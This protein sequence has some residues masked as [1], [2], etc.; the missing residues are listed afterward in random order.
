MEWASEVVKNNYSCHSKKNGG[1][2]GKSHKDLQGLKTDLKRAL[3]ARQVLSF[4]FWVLL[5]CLTS[6]CQRGTSN[7]EVASF[8]PRLLF[9][10]STGLLLVESPLKGDFLEGN[11]SPRG[12][13]PSEEA[14]KCNDEAAVTKTLV[15]F[16]PGCRQ[17]AGRRIGL[18]WPWPW[19]LLARLPYHTGVKT[20]RNTRGWNQTDG[21]FLILVWPWRG[22]AHGPTQ[23]RGC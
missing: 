7:K 20:N 2:G 21:L 3:G 16:W 9:L 18:G 17:A 1:A 13:T 14:G 8:H 11:S 6:T 10:C 5:L 22:A 23:P 4:V 12:P 19:P 15:P